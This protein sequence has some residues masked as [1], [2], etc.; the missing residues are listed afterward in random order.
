LPSVGVIIGKH[1][2]KLLYIGVRNNY[3]AAC[4]NN[5]KTQKKTKHVCFKNWEGVSASMESD[6]IVEGFN[7]AEQQHGVR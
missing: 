4:V 5:N 2:G 6:I 1:T 7:L 3:C